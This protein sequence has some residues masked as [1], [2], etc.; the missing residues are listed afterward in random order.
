MAGF[1]HSSPKIVG[2][3]CITHSKNIFNLVVAKHAPLLTKGFF[4]LEDEI[5]LNPLFVLIPHAKIALCL[6][7]KTIFREF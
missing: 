4:K 7:W 3:R 1:Y 2:S 6:P 5:S